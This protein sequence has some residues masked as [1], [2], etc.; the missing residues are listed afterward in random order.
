VTATVSC[1]NIGQIFDEVQRFPE[2]RSQQKRQEFV[3]L[4]ELLA[5]KPPRYLCEIGSRRGGTTFLLARVCAA[6]ATVISVDKD[7]SI[8]RSMIHRRMGI[9][10][11]RI[12]CIRGDSRFHQ[13]IDRVTSVLGKNSLDCLFIDGDHSLGGVTADF[14]GYSPLVG[15]GGTVVFH[16]I[17]SDY[18]TRF[19]I[20]SESYTG[21]VPEFWRSIKSRFHSG[22]LIEDSEQDGFGLGIIHW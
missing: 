4:L 20:D 1:R 8:G 18:K 3:G 7:L 14:D 11:Q 13:T 5:E 19:G 17:V 16:D 2:F 15:S 10:Q 6:D 22:E 12:V 9:A 21:G